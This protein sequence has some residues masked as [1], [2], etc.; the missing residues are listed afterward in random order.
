MN[1]ISD[2]MCPNCKFKRLSISSTIAPVLVKCGNCEATFTEDFI[3]GYWYK[4]PELSDIEWVMVFAAIDFCSN[5]DGC[6]HLVECHQLKNI[7]NKI[8]LTIPIEAFEK[9]AGPENAD[10]R[11]LPGKR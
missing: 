7:G 10:R 6:F 9:I 1:P 2:F 3:R 8:L 5:L 11:L 4:R